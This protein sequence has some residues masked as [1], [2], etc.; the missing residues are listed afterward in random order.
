[1][2]AGELLTIAL[3]FLAGYVFVTYIFKVLKDAKAM[4][5]EKRRNGDGPPS[6]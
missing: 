3:C 6:P 2:S 1:M 5:E 4:D